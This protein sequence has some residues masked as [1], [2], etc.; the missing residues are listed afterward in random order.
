MAI[1]WACIELFKIESMAMEES[2]KAAPADT[3]SVD[4]GLVE[5][6][7]KAMHSWEDA[8][9]SLVINLEGRA[10]WLLANRCSFVEEDEADTDGVEREM[11]V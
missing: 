3:A 4:L 9:Y 1:L 8:P 6:F 11:S 10:P 2:V 7:N 5:W